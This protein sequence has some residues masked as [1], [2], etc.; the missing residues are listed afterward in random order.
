[1]STP[2]ARLAQLGITLPVATSPVAAYVPTKRSGN[3]LFVSGQLPFH[4]GKLMATGRVP[5]QVSLDVAAACARQCAL[6]AL[7]AIKANVGDLSLVSQV[8]RVGVFV[9]SDLGFT[10]QPKVA[11]G[12]SQLLVDVF[13]DA[14]RHARAAVG[15][16][17]LP[18]GASVEVELLVEL[19]NAQAAS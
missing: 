18:L 10:D 3:L 8:V 7:A 9:C 19:V 4:D 15:N 1:M 13:G 11:N 17:A 16:I 5:S 12:A 14:G 6:N 2:E